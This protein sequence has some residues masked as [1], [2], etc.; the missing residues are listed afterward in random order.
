M[1]L[2]LIQKRSFSLRHALALIGAL[3]VAHLAL[4]TVTVDI[5][6]P[7][8]VS[9][10]TPYK[11]SAAGEHQY[12]EGCWT[13]TA[14]YRLPETYWPIAYKIEYGV[15]AIATSPWITDYGTQDVIYS[16]DTWSECSDYAW[17]EEVVH[18]Q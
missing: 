14:L 6:A 12:W 3:A 1:K 16:A 10:G 7:A 13:E 11:V 4:A 2:N 18:I 5:W 15:M 8:T 17:T 9:S